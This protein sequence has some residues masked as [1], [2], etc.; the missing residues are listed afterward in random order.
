[1]S[2]PLSLSVLPQKV[3]ICQLDK[4][5]SI[6]SWATKDKSFFSVSKTSDELSIICS[7]RHV[8]SD[9]KAEKN[10]RAIKVEGILDFSL[11]GILISILKPLAEAEISVFVISAYPTDYILVKE[12]ELKK[13]LKILGKFFNI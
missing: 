4:D 1:M 10:W 8:P 3:A 11:S 6:P 5:A 12:K 7:Q 13:A 9:V 2:E